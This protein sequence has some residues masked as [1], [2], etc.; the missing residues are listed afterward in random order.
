M[1]HLNENKSN[2]RLFDDNKNEIPFI[3]KQKEIYKIKKRVPVHSQL[4]SMLQPTD[5]SIEIMYG[6][7]PGQSIDQLT[8]KTRL[9]ILK[10]IFIY[11]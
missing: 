7:K 8:I 4:V 1:V 9:K 5:N 3:I 10:K 6:F 11:K 2:I